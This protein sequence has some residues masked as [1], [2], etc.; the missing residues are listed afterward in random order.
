MVP[1][2]V[3]DGASMAEITGKA[4]SVQVAYM[5]MTYEISFAEKVKSEIIDRGFA[6]RNGIY[7]LLILEKA[8]YEIEI[9]LSYK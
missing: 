7:K 6:N 5:G 2:L 9:I 8:G 3:S 4:N 1:L